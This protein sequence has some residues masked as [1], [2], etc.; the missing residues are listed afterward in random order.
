MP[1]RVARGCDH[2]GEHCPA[3][4]AR[5]VLRDL[6]LAWLPPAAPAPLF[7]DPRREGAFRRH[8][9]YAAR[10]VLFDPAYAAVMYD[11]GTQV[12]A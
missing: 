2:A 9:K 5:V 1:A 6:G 8:Q 3:W 4:P 12:A 11:A 10:K 7:A